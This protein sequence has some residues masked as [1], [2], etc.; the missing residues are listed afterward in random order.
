MIKQELINDWAIG[1]KSNMLVITSA[2]SAGLDY[3]S[4]YLILHI[5]APSGL[6]DYAQETGQ[7]GRDRQPTEFIIL[8]ALRWKV[9]WDSNYRSNFL[10]LDRQHMEQYL[11]AGRC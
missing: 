9:L 3:A 4:V 8:F 10:L 6:V 5:D 2:L 1:N 7:R 11:Q